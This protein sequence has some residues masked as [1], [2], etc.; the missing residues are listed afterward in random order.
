[1]A[2][3]QLFDKSKLL[4]LFL[5]AFFICNALVAE[6]IG[7]KI[8]SLEESLG[9]EPWNWNLFGN[10]GS[11][12]FTA[13]V[14]LW[15]IVFIFTDIINEYFGKS[16]VKIASYLA[17]LLICYAFLNIFF[18]INLS[19]ADWWVTV[20]Q[21]KGVDNMQLAYQS[22]FGQSLWII[23]GS[24][25]AFLVGQF[26]DVFVFQRIKKATGDK[27]LWLRATGST[28]VSQ[29]IDSF[30]VLYIAFV[31]G[32]QKWSMSLFL[33]IALL[34]YAYKFIVAVVLTPLLYLIHF[35]IDGWLG[36]ELAEEL[37]REALLKG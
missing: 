28:L 9:L 34:N 19:P 15:P 23:F 31:L 29:F 17:V 36:K 3:I 4:Y 16:G 35:V 32:P 27:H 6:F 33:S 21:D 26:I 1:M 11:L 18:A 22:V 5:L 14:I 12:N 10:T 2:N 13:G 25:V 7:V 37:K 30:I 8:F 20:N 24:L